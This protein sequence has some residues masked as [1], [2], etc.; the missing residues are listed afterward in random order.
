LKTHTN[1]VSVGAIE[2]SSH[3][4]KTVT[5]PAKR[6]KKRGKWGGPKANRVNVIAQG[7]LS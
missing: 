7:K 3:N 2:P 4:G 1:V 6:K 5:K